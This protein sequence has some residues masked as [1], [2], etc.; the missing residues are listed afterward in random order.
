MKFPAAWG[1]QSLREGEADDIEH[2]CHL[3][4]R[5]SRGYGSA[6]LSSPF[7]DAGANPYFKLT[8]HRNPRPHSALRL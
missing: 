2:A 5:S 6:S 7:P 8:A 3:R 1:H 4:S